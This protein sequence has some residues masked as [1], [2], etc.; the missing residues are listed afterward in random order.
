MLQEKQWRL[1]MQSETILVVDDDPGALEFCC[2]V[3]AHG[4]YNV[5]RAASGQEAFEI[6]RNGERIDMALVDVM[7]PAMN[8]IEL[9]KRIENLERRPKLALISG[10]SP[11]EVERLI[12]GE[13]AGY[14]IFWKPF[15]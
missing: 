6:C 4:G 10:Y 7:M 8:G 1:K 15:E 12:E 5:L 3:L 14:R 2:S 11:D 13:G 9:V